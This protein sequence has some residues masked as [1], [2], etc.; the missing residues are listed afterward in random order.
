LTFDFNKN[1]LKKMKRIGILSFMSLL[2]ILSMAQTAAP[3]RDLTED[4]MLTAAAIIIAGFT[5]VLMLLLIILLFK[6][7]A[8]LTAMMPHTEEDLEY[9]KQDF[10]S[11]LFQLR[12]LSMERKL[13]LE[14]DYDGIQELDNPTPPWFMFLFYSTILFAIGYGIIYHAMG[15]GK[16]MENEYVAEVKDAEIRREAYLK[17][18]AN[19]VNETNVTLITE[20]AGQE[21]G[22]AIYDNNCVACHGAMGEGKVGPNL[23]DGYWI[24]GGSIQKIFKTVTEGV[25]EKGMISWKKQLN[26]LQI[27]KVSSFILTFQGTN[28]PNPK[29]PQ[30]QL[31]GAPNADTTQPKATEQTSQL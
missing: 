25:P 10:W 4:Q 7:R 29:E 18:F 20:K 12:P 11:R 2:P 17:K 26:P 1:I 6:L 28:P 21:E 15:N 22:K 27:Q 30:G 24:H 14:H 9:Q 13:L 23:A 31:E 5:L 19:S 16:V 8:R 3:K